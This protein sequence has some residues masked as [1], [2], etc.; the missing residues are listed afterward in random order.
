M[1]QNLYIIL[2]LIMAI[3]FAISGCAAS[4]APS[5]VRESSRKADF[6]P[7]GEPRAP[8]RQIAPGD[9]RTAAGSDASHAPIAREAVYLAAAMPV[10]TGESGSPRAVDGVSECWQPL[11][12]RLE[13]DPGVKAE[14][15]RYFCSLPGYSPMPMGT[16][17]KELFTNAF[18]R[19]PKAPSDGAPAQPRVRIYRNVVT[20]VNMEKCKDFLAEHSA[21][22][23]A[24]EK[25]Y[26]VP[27]EI[28]ASLLFVET[29]LGTVMG[30]ENAFWSLACM[31]A[32]ESPSWME[33]GLEGIP[34]TDEHTGWL[35]EKLTDK[36]NWAY[37]ELRALLNFCSVQG[38]DPL[39]LP[40][41]VY[42]AIGIC[43]FMPSNLGLYGA[44][45]N[46]DGVVD[47]FSPSDAI[48][49]AASYLSKHGWSANMAVD[50]Q[51]AVLKRY[52]N[53]NIYA[54]TILTLGE[55]LRTGVVQTG[56]PDAVVASAG[57]A[58]K[59]M[60]KSG[61]KKTGAQKAGLQKGAKAQ[62]GAQVARPVKGGAVKSGGKTKSAR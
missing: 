41:S 43:Q 19:K 9:F 32:A 34:I 52:N 3:F 21:A 33:G 62:T 35:Q 60:P 25:K 29:R 40:G 15:A 6:T 18:L 14:T 31:A 51:R 56:P 45:G 2:C 12:R 38:L 46:G 24:M 1:R 48:F 23:A 58:K 36:S 10:S 17:V 28:V 27:K 57:K 11:V 61:V 37:K 55:S 7:V 47:L 42:G 39:V 4:P 50:K 16:K 30:N 13:R 49:S 44:D 59:T 53:L 22:F 5:G 20:A 8:N 54:N 26:A